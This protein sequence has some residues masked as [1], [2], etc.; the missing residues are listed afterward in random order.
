LIEIFL[1]GI[2]KLRSVVVPDKADN[3]P[4]RVDIEARQIGG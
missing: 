4:Y 3:P 2:E 1:D